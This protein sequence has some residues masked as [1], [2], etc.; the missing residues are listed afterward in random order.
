MDYLGNSRPTEAEEDD[1]GPGDS[2]SQ[3]TRSETSRAERAAR[4]AAI[5]AQREALAQQQD[6]ERQ[7]ME[8]QQRLHAEEEERDARL[9]AEAEELRHR[10]RAEEEALRSRQR[11]ME[12]DRRER[13]EAMALAMAQRR[14]DL[15]LATDLAILEAQEKTASV[16]GD[17]TYPRTVVETSARAATTVRPASIAAAPWAYRQMTTVGQ[18]RTAT[19]P[20]PSLGQVSRSREERADHSVGPELPRPG[21]KAEEDKPLPQQQR[22]GQQAAVRATQENARGTPDPRTTSPRKTTVQACTPQPVPLQPAAQRQPQ[23]WEPSPKAATWRA[24]VPAVVEEPAPET[25]P[26]RREDARP[27]QPQPS[28]RSTTDHLEALYHQQAQLIGALQAPK[29][30]IP[31]FNGDPL[32]YAQFIRAYEDNVEKVVHDNAARLARLVQL[33]SGEAARVVNCCLLMPADQGYP[34]AR[35]LLKQ[36]FGDDYTIVNLWVSRLTEGRMNGLREYADDLRSCLETLTAMDAAQE[37]DTMGNLA[38]VVGKLPNYLQSRWRGQAQHLRREGRRPRLRDVVAFVEEAADE[39]EDPVFGL[40]RPAKPARAE[41]TPHS[42]FAATAILQ[43]CPVC[44]Q[45][46]KAIGCPHPEVPEPRDRGRRQ[47]WIRGCA[48]PA[49]SPDT[50]SATASTRAGARPRGAEEKHATLLHDAPRPRSDRN[51]G[52]RPRREGQ[53]D[54]AVERTEG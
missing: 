27:T 17:Q 22:P 9:T 35:Q 42:S 37:M 1:I 3:Y 54:V 32:M 12:R 14:A 11:A 4:R 36:R 5:L 52:S 45:N 43:Q 7:E 39:A 46:H 50:P 15:Q 10:Q 23:L 49:W 26:S 31:P 13:Q 38:K 8:L 2:V 51:R 29:V 47:S 18:P 53:Q 30:A 20:Q 28:P 40:P 6:L 34:R 24:T 33:C 21:H 19:A 44:Q 16:V 41:K 48:L 25:Y